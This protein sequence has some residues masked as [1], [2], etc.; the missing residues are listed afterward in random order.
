LGHRTA[1]HLAGQQRDKLEVKEERNKKEAPSPPPTAASPS[2]KLKRQRSLAPR[3]YTPEFERFWTG[4]PKTKTTNPKPEAFDV[5]EK[6]T[7]EDQSAATA[8]LPA[9]S[10]HCRQQFNGYQPP[11]AAV[12]LRKRRFDDFAPSPA[13][14]PNPEKIRAGQL[15]KARAHFS[16]EWRETWGARPGEPGCT[17]PADIVSDARQ[18]AG[19]LQ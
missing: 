10:V 6:L 7:P 12:Y 5:W 15:A 4:Y 1:G 16:G 9:F 2:A 14:V 13:A 18:E 17:I 8:S 19:G 3:V 11:G